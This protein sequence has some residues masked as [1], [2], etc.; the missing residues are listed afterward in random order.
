MFRGS[1]A[2]KRVGGELCDPADESP[3]S[4]ILFAGEP[5]NVTMAGPDGLL[6]L[7]RRADEGGSWADDWLGFALG[8]RC[9]IPLDEES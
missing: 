6:N 2:R 8:Q 4:E 1:A 5:A 9:V 3:V 7:M